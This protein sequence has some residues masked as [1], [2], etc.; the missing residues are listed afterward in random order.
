MIDEDIINDIFNEK[1]SDR[2]NKSEK[3]KSLPEIKKHLIEK[4]KL[5]FNKIGNKK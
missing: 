3:K 5:F 1:L 2:K 4:I